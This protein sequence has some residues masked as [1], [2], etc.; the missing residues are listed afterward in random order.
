MNGLL[1]KDLLLMR[2]SV[3]PMAVLAVIFEVVFA[4]N[5]PAMMFIIG[6]ALPSSVAGTVFVYDHSSGWNAYAVSSGVDRREIMRCKY[7]Y[8][9]IL[10]CVGIA[11]G[12]VGVA[13]NGA[14]KGGLPDPAELAVG[15]L[16]GVSV[17]IV[18]GSVICVANTITSP[19]RARALELILC[20]GT[21]MAVTIV[22]TETADVLGNVPL[23]VPAVMLV[24]SLGVL[25][26]SYW[27]AQRKFATKDL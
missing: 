10:A 9:M 19:M 4:R 12:L 23:T 6:A 17:A 22:S 18:M 1:L 25:A 24:A 20:V 7:V 21:I 13:V 14:V 16:I 11:M 15:L 26:A 5:S 2:S 3:V 8:C 27:M